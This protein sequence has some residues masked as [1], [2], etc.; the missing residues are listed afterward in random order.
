[1]TVENGSSRAG[2]LL[3]FKKLADGATALSCRRADG[4]VAWQK[5]PAERAGFFIRHDLAHYAVETVLGFSLGFYGLMAAGWEF[6]DFGAPWPRGP[7]P[8]DADPAE[9]ILVSLMPSARTTLRGRRNSLRNSLRGFWAKQRR[10]W[11]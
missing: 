11:Y 4:T 6:G 1:M 9:L 5:M 7:L 3:R 8:V 2:L 10:H